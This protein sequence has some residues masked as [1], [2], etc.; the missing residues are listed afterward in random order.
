MQP[1]LVIKK[2]STGPAVIKWQQFLQTQ[3]NSLTADGIFGGDTLA[4]T[5][6]FQQQQGLDADGIVGNNTYAAA[7]VLGFIIAL[8]I[9]DFIGIDVYH[10]DGAVNWDAVQTDPQQITFAYIKATEGTGFNDPTFATNRTNALAAGLKVGAYHFYHPELSPVDQANFFTAA[11]TALQP[12]ELPPA[13]DFE[14]E[15]LGGISTAQ[16]TADVNTFITTVQNALGVTP[17]IYTNY[18][19]WVY[20]LGNPTNFTQYKLWV[21]DYTNPLPELFGGWNDWAI[22]QFADKG[23]VAGI[24]NGHS[25]DMNKY[26]ADSGLM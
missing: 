2:G 7:A 9:A 16:A 6:V 13:L 22:W 4:A 18:N 8:D 1:L 24:D 19:S 21:A 25:T 26:N 12:N 5:I 3:G 20:V 23:L 14:P 11:I 15:S 10:N 17:V